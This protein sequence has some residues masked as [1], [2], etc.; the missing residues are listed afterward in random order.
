MNVI[1]IDNTKKIIFIIVA[2]MVGK[3]A[4]HRQETS[5]LKIPIDFIYN[6]KNVFSNMPFVPKH[7]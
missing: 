6:R 7:F 1:A 4:A 3:R 2:T 5:N